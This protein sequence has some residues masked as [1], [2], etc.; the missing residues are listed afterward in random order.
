M[1]R[2]LAKAMRHRKLESKKAEAAPAGDE[3]PLAAGAG[4]TPIAEEPEPIAEEPEPIAEAALWPEAGVKVAVGVEH[5]QHSLRLG[6]TGVSEGPAPDDPRE[7]IVEL[8]SAAVLSSLRVPGSL[9]T[10]IGE[11]VKHS[12]KS[13]MRPSDCGTMVLSS[14]LFWL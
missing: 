12:S 10:S 8:D 3:A 1:R 6:E 2:A 5:L 7:V 14:L 9:M 11:S 4:D 13:R